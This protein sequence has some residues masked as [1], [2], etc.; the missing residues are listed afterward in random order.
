MRR[1]FASLSALLTATSLLVPVSGEVSAQSSVRRHY[2]TDPATGQQYYHTHSG[3]RGH[4]HQ[5]RVTTTTTTSAARFVTRDFSIQGR[6]MHDTNNVRRSF[7]MRGNDGVRRRIDVPRNIRVLDNRTGKRL[8]VHELHNGDHIRVSGRQTDR[9]RW[10][11][12]QIRLL[13]KG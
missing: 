7:V 6:V 2:H 11:A 9:Q 8:S 5:T 13:A 12:H 1:A 10:R 3:T 4:R